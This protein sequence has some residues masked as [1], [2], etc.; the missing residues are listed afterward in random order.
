[1]HHNFYKRRRLKNTNNLTLTWRELWTYSGLGTRINFLPVL[2]NLFTTFSRCR[3]IFTRLCWA[4]NPVTIR[5]FVCCL[6]VCFFFFITSF[7]P[8]QILCLE[9]A[10]RLFLFSS[11]SLIFHYGFLYKGLLLSS[12][13]LFL[14]AIF[15]DIWGK[16]KEKQ[17]IIITWNAQTFDGKYQHNNFTNLLLISLEGWNSSLLTRS[18]FLV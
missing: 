3:K 18:D 11:C 16:A 10:V 5:V 1:M 2:R 13:S 9:P 17:T 14:T 7:K 8:I 6:L 12:W 4:S 15:W